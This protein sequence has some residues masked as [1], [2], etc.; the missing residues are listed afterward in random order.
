M[1]NIWAHIQFG[2]EVLSA[3]Q[4]ERPMENRSWKTAFQ[5]GCQG[6]D[7]LF[8]DHFLPWQPSTSLNKL[9]SLMHGVRCGPFL[10]S[11]F[12]EVRDRP[13]TDPAVAYTLGFLLHHILDRHLHPFIFSRSGFKKWHHQRYETALDSAVLFRR[14]SISTG[15]TPVIPEVDTDGRLPGGFATDFLRVVSLHYPVLAKQ[16]TAE[17]L[18]RAVAQMMRAQRL[19][20][21]PTGWKSKLLLG[22][23]TP[24]SP[25][26]RLPE[27]DVLNESRQPWI[28]PTD[29]TVIH[30]SSA[31]DLWD[32]ALEDA[33]STTFA[34]IEWLKA[35]DSEQ[36][37]ERK[38]R[39][40][41][42]LRDVSY[43]TG[44]PC[45]GARITYADSVVPV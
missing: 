32:V 3:I 6:P 27:W 13:M 22:Q 43:E 19:F 21:D 5:L 4:S 1:P 9:G 20:F 14:A 11:L 17:Q 36:A 26:R 30:H 24:F 35:E 34:G 41:E 44:L 37:A 10:L 40:S 2:K 39:F 8:Y 42:L 38:E 23:I 15:L 31:L 45:D 7:F 25:P 33:F 29:R 16:M 18:D 28:D 12:D